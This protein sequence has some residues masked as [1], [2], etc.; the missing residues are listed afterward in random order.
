MFGDIPDFRILNPTDEM[1]DIAAGLLMC[2]EAGAVATRDDGSQFE[3]F[4]SAI[5]VSQGSKL[6]TCGKYSVYKN[7]FG[8]GAGY[9]S[10]RLRSRNSLMKLQSGHWCP[11]PGKTTN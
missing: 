7:G 8:G 11:T 6:A 2:E 5:S 10:L 3:V 9:C 1:D 4:V